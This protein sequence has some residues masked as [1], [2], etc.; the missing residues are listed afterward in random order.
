MIYL[1][2]HGEA[3]AQE[4]DPNRPLTDTGAE[5]VDDVGMFLARATVSVSTIFHSGKLRAEQ[6]ADILAEH[7]TPERPPEPMDDIGATDPTDNI[8][9]ELDQWSEGVML[10]SHM[11]FVG[12]LAGRLVVGDEHRP[13]V[14]F[15]PGTVVALER[16]GD[17]A[18][19]VGWMIRPELVRP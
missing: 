9:S 2:Q 17:D 12:R 1:L 7:L 13:P 14:A 15:V 8:A 10:V 16:A 5:Q 19:V 18:W 3:L 11:P 6:S 4:A